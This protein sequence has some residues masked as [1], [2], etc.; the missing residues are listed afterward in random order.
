MRVQKQVRPE[1]SAAPSISTPF[2][3]PSLKA[4]ATTFSERPAASAAS[5]LGNSCDDESR[6][7]AP[8][9][10]RGRREGGGSVSE[11]LRS[12]AA[13]FIHSPARTATAE[14]RSGDATTHLGG[15]GGVGLLLLNV[16]HLNFGSEGVVG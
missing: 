9:G 8:R 10:R 14:T 7:G 5:F 3:P 11:R 6:G 13:D 15:L 16:G 2:F 4:L 12:E 1:V